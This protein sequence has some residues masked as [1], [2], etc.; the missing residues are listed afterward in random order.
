MI[1]SILMTKVLSP[2]VQYDNKIFPNWSTATGYG[3]FCV[4]LLQYY[5]EK[6]TEHVSHNQDGNS[7]I[8]CGPIGTLGH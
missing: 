6:M 1:G 3:E 5:P 2:L 4:W 7:F 8:A